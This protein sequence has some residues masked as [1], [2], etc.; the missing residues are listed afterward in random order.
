MDIE[1]DD[2]LSN[3]AKNF[4]TQSFKIARPADILKADLSLVRKMKD[5]A[6]LNLNHIDNF[7]DL[8]IED[9]V[10][11]NIYDNHEI[12]VR[13]FVPKALEK[14][15]LITVFFHGGG[16]SLGSRITHHHTVGFLTR[17]TNSIWLSVE[18]RRC[19]DE[20]RYPIPYQDCR[21]VVE[22]AIENKNKLGSECRQLGICGDSAGGQMAS[23]IA[24][25]LKENLDYQIL[26]YPCVHFSNDYQS[27]K[28]FTQEC[29]FLVPEVVNFFRKNLTDQPELHADHLSPIMYN[30]FSKLPRCLIIAAELDPLVD[31]SKSYYNKLKDN[32][33]D[34]Q[35]GILAGTIH[36][37]FSQP[38][39]FQ[40]AFK[41]VENLISSFLLNS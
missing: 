24:H 36:G 26:I 29:F 8:E 4:I 2:R 35:L 25:E 9:F 19:P 30:D 18:Y 33:I 15:P 41:K 27:A 31:Q 38:L 14:N 40:D 23:I 5:Q 20:G 39:M 28:D 17:K 32:K 21:S 10:V 1:L 37:F 22:W 6:C 13:K 34:C 11:R 12:L 7:D 16:F 3:E